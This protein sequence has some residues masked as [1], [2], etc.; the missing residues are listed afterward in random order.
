[1]LLYAL[2]DPSSEVRVAAVA[3]L[4]VVGG[5]RAL[6]ALFESADRGVDGALA[7]VG[8]I[9]G[10]RDV[11]AIMQ[12]VKDGDVTQ[13]KPALQVMLERP[14]FPLQGKL[15]IVR[16][17]AQLGSAGARNHL[18]QWLDAWKQSGDP[19]LREALFEAIKRIDAAE[20]R[21]AAAPGAK[22][23]AT[24]GATAAAPAKPAPANP[25]PA[26]AKLDAAPLAARRAA[27]PKPEAKI[28]EARVTGGKP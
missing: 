25:E 12:R 15:A 7:A 28:A 10:T 1:V 18:V 11:K 2:D 16:E 9:A 23:P 5:A 3:S 19:R 22:P 24:S 21:Q 6:P 4:A 26:I 8:K 20:A 14:N 17:V 27:V 13:I